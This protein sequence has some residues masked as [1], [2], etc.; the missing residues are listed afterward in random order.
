MTI[1]LLFT[2]K[3]L[4]S[5]PTNRLFWIYK[6]FPTE[7]CGTSGIGFQQVG[8]IRF[9]IVVVAVVLLQLLLMMLLLLLLVF[10]FKLLLLLLIMMAM[11]FLDICFCVDTFFSMPGCERHNRGGS[12]LWVAFGRGFRKASKQ[13][14]SSCGFCSGVEKE[15]KYNMQITYWN[16]V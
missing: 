8:K 6:N 11:I 3:S 2:S 9:Y 5:L 12:P 15:V 4:I 16:R 10:L 14:E 1:I 13:G 7:K